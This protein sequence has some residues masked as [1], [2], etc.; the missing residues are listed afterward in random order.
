VYT[1]LLNC[2]SI[3]FLK[4]CESTS[5]Y[6]DP[7]HLLLLIVKLLNGTLINRKLEDAMLHTQKYITR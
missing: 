6:L 1:L 5:N 2:C 4:M 7:V 3:L